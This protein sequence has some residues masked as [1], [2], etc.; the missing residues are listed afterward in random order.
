M[1]Q[2]K[3]IKLL[4]R[5]L[6][7]LFVT[8]HIGLTGFVWLLCCSLIWSGEATKIFMPIF[9]IIIFPSFPPFFICCWDN[10]K[11]FEKFSNLSDRKKWATV[12]GLDSKSYSTISKSQEL[13]WNSIKLGGRVNSAISRVFSH[14]KIICFDKMIFKLH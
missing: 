13:A 2:E 1:S 11:N 5:A 3:S 9:Y 7:K 4:N 8:E 10:F 6:A 14:V 12:V